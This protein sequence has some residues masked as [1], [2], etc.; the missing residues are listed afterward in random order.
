MTPCLQFL[1]TNP[2]LK[3]VY[4]KTKGFVP[5]RVDSFSPIIVWR[6]LERVFGKSA[7]PDQTPQNALS[8]QGLPC[9]QIVQ[10]FFSRN[11]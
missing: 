6:P 7:D 9:L 5:F 3:E 1:H 8:D 4:S 2:Y 11:I 10:S